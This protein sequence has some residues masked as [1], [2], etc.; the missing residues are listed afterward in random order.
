VAPLFA[1]SLFAACRLCEVKWC[2]HPLHPCLHAAL[3][4]ALLAALAAY[5]LR[6]L[7]LRRFTKWPHW[8]PV[9]NMAA[10]NAKAK[11]EAAAKREARYDTR[12]Q[13]QQGKRPA[14][15]AG[16]AAAAAADGNGAAAEQPAAK[17]QRLDR[18]GRLDGATA[19]MVVAMQVGS[20]LQRSVCTI[21]L[22]STG[23]T[24]A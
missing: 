10:L 6:C 14:D 7:L 13:Q 5:M 17:Q 9:R 24:T 1:V 19:G 12:S 16:G 18:P 11:Q 8:A 4:A 2:G 3:H 23:H 21:E 22:A 20:L 15:S